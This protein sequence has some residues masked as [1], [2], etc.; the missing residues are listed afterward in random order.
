MFAIIRS[1]GKQYRVREGD[2]IDVELI[3]VPEGS[4]VTLEEVLVIERDEGATVGTPLVDGASVTATV[5]AHGR[6]K[7]VTFF[8]YKNKTRQKR[9]RGHR[10]HQTRLQ[11][12]AISPGG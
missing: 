1:G 2:H 7:K 4:D 10:Q 9:M 8:H 11:I 5:E 6:A 3:D 12:T